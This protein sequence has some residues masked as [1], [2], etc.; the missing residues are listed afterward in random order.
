LLRCIPSAKCIVTGCGYIQPFSV[1][2]QLPSEL[3]AGSPTYAGQTCLPSSPR[4]SLRI[5]LGQ[6][7]AP[8]KTRYT[9]CR[10]ILRRPAIRD[11]VS[12]SPKSRRNSWLSMEGLGRLQM[13]LAFALA[14]PISG[15]ETPP[16]PESCSPAPRYSLIAQCPR[17]K[18]EAFEMTSKLSVRSSGPPTHQLRRLWRDRAGI[19]PAALVRSLLHLTRECLSNALRDSLARF[20]ARQVWGAPPDSGTHP[21]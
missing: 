17:G 16:A 3:F 12:P 19:G 14:I 8:F 10:A 21:A 9:L 20:Q 5:P 11:G 6:P 18:S 4:S 1:L 2:D 13:P 15:R 7:T